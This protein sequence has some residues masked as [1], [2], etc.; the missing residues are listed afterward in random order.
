LEHGAGN[1]FDRILDEKSGAAC[2]LRS[3][4]RPAPVLFR[5]QERASRLE[6]RLVSDLERSSESVWHGIS[7]KAIPT[8][9]SSS[10]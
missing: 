1:K 3:N 6:A 10:L 5:E 9:A 7:R 4:D 2:A 8:L